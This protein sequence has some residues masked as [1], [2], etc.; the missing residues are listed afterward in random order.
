[1][2]TMAV[3]AVDALSRSLDRAI[4]QARAAAG[5][6]P[7]ESLQTGE[8]RLAAQ[9]RACAADPDTSDEVRAALAHRV[10]FARVER[11][12][13]Q[14]DSASARRHQK[15]RRR[16][17]ARALSALRQRTYRVMVR[18][19]MRARASAVDDGRA[20]STAPKLSMR[21]ARRYQIARLVSRLPARARWEAVSPDGASSRLSNAHA[22]LACAASACFSRWGEGETWHV[23]LLAAERDYK[24]SSIEPE[25]AT[26]CAAAERF[27]AEVLPPDATEDS[28][29]ALGSRFADLQLSTI[30]SSARQTEETRGLSRGALIASVRD[31]ARGCVEVGARR[32]RIRPALVRV[33]RERSPAHEAKRDSEAARRVADALRAAEGVDHGVKLLRADVTRV[34]KAREAYEQGLVTLRALRAQ[35]SWSASASLRAARAAKAVR[36][37]E[38]YA[39]LNSFYGVL[40]EESA[41]KLETETRAWRIASAELRAR[42]GAAKNGFYKVFVDKTLRLAHETQSPVRPFAPALPGEV[43]PPSPRR[44]ARETLFKVAAPVYW[45]QGVSGWVYADSG[46]AVWTRESGLLY[47]VA[48]PGPRPMSVCAREPWF[49]TMLGWI[50]RDK[51]RLSSDEFS[52]ALDEDCN[53]GE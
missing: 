12:D 46:A 43:N 25:I 33:E 34:E 13:V 31:S 4:A 36:R 49:A 35:A 28:V 19:N 14:L 10:A 30:I 45:L 27:A 47:P 23:D 2:P 48:R 41:E 53:P 40:P 42:I 21:D 39:A 38:N 32:A 16:L 50:A 24:G 7:R 1:M 37:W 44:L 5:S 26:A 3:D 8:T 17:L 29:R 52:P 51:L 15:A 6:T 9:A 18:A 20:G 11:F 22:L